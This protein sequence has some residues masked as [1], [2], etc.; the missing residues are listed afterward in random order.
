MHFEVHSPPIVRLVLGHWTWIKAT[1]EPTTRMNP[2]HV[3][4]SWFP[5]SVDLYVEIVEEADDF[6]RTE[7]V[8][9]VRVEALR[10]PGEKGFFV[11]ISSKSTF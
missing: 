2:I 6:F 11:K 10:V 1:N 5:H 3:T 4:W 7:I 9:L 8:L